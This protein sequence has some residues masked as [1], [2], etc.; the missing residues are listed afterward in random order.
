MSSRY[1]SSTNLGTRKREAPTPTP[2]GNGNGNGF[3]LGLRLGSNANDN[4]KR[5]KIG[6]SLKPLQPVRG[7]GGG[8]VGNLH[9]STSSSLSSPTPAQ[10]TFTGQSSVSVLSNASVNSYDHH[11]SGG[12]A[13][14]I[15]TTSLIPV[16]KYGLPSSSMSLLPG[17]KQLGKTRRQSFKP[18]QS[19]SGGIGMGIGLGLPGSMG[20]GIGMGMGCSGDEW[21][22]G[23]M[24]EQ[25]QE[26]ED[27]EF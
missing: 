18:R 9:Y 4:P 5:Q 8:G 11:P 13:T 14:T 26:Q 2:F 27:E 24:E 7:G 3:G 23:V 10:R 20:L 21:G 12:K 15:T 16:V 1:P 22:R 17:G 6:S 25:E 19:V